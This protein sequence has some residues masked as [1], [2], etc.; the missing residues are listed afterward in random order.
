MLAPLPRWRHLAEK[1]AAGAWQGFLKGGGTAGREP[2]LVKCH[3]PQTTWLTSSRS[4]HGKGP[5]QVED[6]K[7]GCSKPLKEWTLIVSPFGQLKVRLPCHVSVCS[8]DPHRYPNADRVFVTMSGTS[9]KPPHS[10][11]L[12]DLHVKYDEALTEMAI[13]S[14]D[15]DGTA[16]VDVR[17][18][19][20]FGMC[21]KTGGKATAAHE[22]ILPV[23]I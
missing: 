12:D 3:C 23:A 16:T 7:Q 4:R 8:L 18:P 22:V 1:I 6:S 2:W 14:S 9:T 10:A 13:T 5:A 17:I 15:I 19:V 20:K 11:N 21:S